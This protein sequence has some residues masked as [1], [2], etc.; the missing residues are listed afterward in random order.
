MP[1]VVFADEQDDI[2]SLRTKLEGVGDGSV[3]VVV[4]RE[5]QALVSPIAIRLLQR[6]GEALALD[7]S[8]VS[9]N[10]S[11]R[12]IASEEGLRVFGSPQ[13]YRRTVEREASPTTHF[14][15][16]L[17]QLFG[18]IS[19]L[20][21]TAL[22]LGVVLFVVGL[23][24]VLL[25]SAV[26]TVTPRTEVVGGVVPVEA[27][28]GIRTV[29]LE[30]GRVPARA[31]Y[32]LVE[33][34]D[35]TAPGEGRA[36]DVGRAVGIVTLTNRNSQEMVVPQG[37]V[38]ST[39]D[40]IRFR[41]DAEVRLAPGLGQTGRVR[42]VAAEP[43]AAGNVPRLRINRVEG[44]LQYYVLVQNDEPTAGGG[45]HAIPQVTADDRDRL[46]TQVM[47]RAREAALEELATMVRDREMLVD[48]S[49]EFTPLGV[50]F[51]REI[52]QEART[53]NVRIKARVAA[54]I[55]NLD[56]VEQVARHKW[57]PTVRPGF[58]LT[59][60][61][62]Q[63]KPP[64]LIQ[65]D[66][67]VVTLAARLEATTFSHVNVARVQQFVRWRRPP[68]AERELL[69]VFDLARPPEIRIEPSWAERAYRVKVLVDLK[70]GS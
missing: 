15:E 47:E 25:P 57:K 40:G 44:H 31:V 66:G 38:V 4:P 5:N 13:A 55:V 23:V 9:S 18:R 34:S 16:A 58:E 30:A 65:V 42:V 3:A 17:R 12:R 35:Q 43:G 20:V 64:E 28:P 63:M 59:P 54:T 56:D 52:G 69:R 70:A 36:A 39:S 32:L 14:Q 21:T 49:V 2:A 24:Y 46:Q 51:D 60:D 22:V 37:T 8:L 26:V 67:R 1:R 11:L 6:H 53:L 45:V 10:P 41:T 62:V 19:S 29:D 48:E 68:E 33:A 61:A 27:N 50:A 7:I